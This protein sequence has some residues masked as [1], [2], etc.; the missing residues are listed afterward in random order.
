MTRM[1]ILGGAAAV[2]LGAVAPAARAQQVDA[3]ATATYGEIELSSG[4]ANDPYRVT[5]TSGG[6]IDAASISSGCT[7]MV[8][9]APDFEVTYEADSLPLTFGVDASVDTTLVIN[10]PDGDWTCDDDSGGGTDPEVTYAR[11]RSGTYDVWVGAFGGDSGSAE[12]FVTEL[13]RDGA[14]SAASGDGHPDASAT[15]A[16]GEIRL[17][18]GFKNDPYRVD[19]LAGGSLNASAVDDA[20]AGTIATAP[21][22][23][24]TFEAGSLPL[25]I[26]ATSDGDVTLVVNGPDGEWHCDD[27]S[28][29]GSDAELTFQRPASGVYDVWV[30]AYDGDSVAA[31]LSITELR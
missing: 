16:Y 13:G 6:T 23:Q 22:F 3:S 11:P 8:A 26:R 18:T 20:C 19:V 2:C 21:D 15:A 25:T 7:G 24:L 12:L 4:F 28:G 29:G 27:D 1:W 30:G 17:S 10:G 14:G 31:E 9:S 5:V